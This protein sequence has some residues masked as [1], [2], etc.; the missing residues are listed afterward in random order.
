[1]RCFILGQIPP[2][3]HGS[4]IMTMTL[5][6]ILENTGFEVHVLSRNISLKIEDMGK[7]IPSKVIRFLK[8]ILQLFNLRKDLLESDKI[9]LFI[10]NQPLLILSDILFALLAKRKK[11]QIILY[12]HTQD[13]SNVY[14]R[15]RFKCSL[16]RFLGKCSNYVVVLSPVFIEDVSK[17]FDHQKIRV[18]PN[19]VSNNLFEDRKNV[20]NSNSHNDLLIQPKHYLLFLSN[21][22][23]SKGVMDFIDF[24]LSTASKNNYTFVIAGATSNY[25]YTA[26]VKRKIK[27]SFYSSRFVFM[28]KVSLT[29]GHELIRNSRILFF[30]STYQFE[31][32]PL[33]LLQA[34]SLGIP[35]V[36]YDNG[37]IKEIIRDGE[38]GYCLKKRG[39]KELED[40]FEMIERDPKQY[41]AMSKKSRSHYSKF[42][43]NEIY[44]QS[45]ID[46]LC[47]DL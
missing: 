20:H 18:I 28:G 15:S 4:S 30:P 16:L 26:E 2:P 41:L 44:S 45:W 36:A 14:G 21:L 10:T 5:R 19:T 42:Y 8:L 24:A 12:L 3:L 23:P 46:L 43:S 39:P 35:V 31:A 34:I 22:I 9:V 17:F 7:L 13:F 47:A 32:Q 11:A 40:A 25:S 27:E 29:Q 33:T 1:M 6:E 38:N 37:S